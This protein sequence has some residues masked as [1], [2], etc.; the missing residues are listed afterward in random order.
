MPLSVLALAEP[1]VKLVALFWPLPEVAP[2]TTDSNSWLAAT[3]RVKGEI[4]GNE[5]LLVDGN[6]EGPIS[7]GQHRLVVGRDG[8]VAGG[9]T[10]REIVIY[11]K[12]DGN[13]NV[14]TESIDIKKGASA[15]G[16]LTTRHIVIEDGANFKGTIDIGESSKQADKAIARAAS[17]SAYEPSRVA[18]GIATKGFAVLVGIFDGV[19]E[20]QQH[21][22]VRLNGD[23]L[24][25]AS[26]LGAPQ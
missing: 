24:W 12:V 6:V 3:M 7:L 19:W 4:S 23:G 13:R 17:A 1:F 21:D 5:D 11:G 9:L 10:A 15:V 18:Q 2:P 25:S 16:H 14:G 8:E 26:Q 20:R 22:R